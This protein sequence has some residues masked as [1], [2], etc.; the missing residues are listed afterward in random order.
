LPRFVVPVDVAL[1]V[2]ELVSVD[3]AVVAVFV[4]V[5]VAE[6]TAVLVAELV[7][8]VVVVA[9]VVAVVVAELAAVLLAV[10]DLVL[11]AVVAVLVC[12]DVAELVADVVAE[13]VAVVVVAAHE[14]HM[15]GQK[16]RTAGSTLQNL[17]RVA[18]S[19]LSRAPW[20]SSAHGMYSV[21]NSSDTTHLAWQAESYA[22]SA[23]PGGSNTYPLSL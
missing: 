3:V 23:I 13:L 8:V 17:P 21:S 19:L 18:Q 7:A 10:V 22:S 6:L 1:V 9:E 12:V 11:V 14:P 15:T 2:I 20:H 5:V 4:W 16:L